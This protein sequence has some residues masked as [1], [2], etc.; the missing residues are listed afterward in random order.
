MRLLTVQLVQRSN[1][2]RRPHRTSEITSEDWWAIIAY[3]CS[4]LRSILQIRVG[5]YHWRYPPGFEGMPVESNRRTGTQTMVEILVGEGSDC[6]EESIKGSSN[7]SGIHATAATYRG[8]PEHLHQRRQHESNKITVEEVVGLMMALATTPLERRL[9]TWMTNTRYRILL[10]SDKC[11]AF[12][13]EWMVNYWFFTLS[14]FTQVILCSV[15]EIKVNSW[16]C[17]IVQNSV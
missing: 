11:I 3:L 16:T 15:R 10:P 1:S 8:N 14:I 6:R 7:G 17:I 4:G 9:T 12:T 13:S 5:E 2:H